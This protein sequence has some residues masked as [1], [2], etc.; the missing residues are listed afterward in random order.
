MYRLYPLNGCKKPCHQSALQG[1]EMVA[2]SN[3][4]RPIAH[5]KQIIGGEVGARLVVGNVCTHKGDD[6]KRVIEHHPCQPANK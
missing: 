6:C 1:A 4:A 5:Y 2:G 3:P